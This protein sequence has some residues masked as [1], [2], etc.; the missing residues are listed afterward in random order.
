MSCPSLDLSPIEHAWYEL[1]RRVKDGY[2]H[3]PSNLEIFSQMLVEQWNNLNQD[4][5]HRLR[6]TVNERIKTCISARSGHTPY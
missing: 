4:R 6:D 1:S 5:L 2:F 3:P